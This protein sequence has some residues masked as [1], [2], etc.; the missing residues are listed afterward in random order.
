[1]KGERTL[2]YSAGELIYYNLSSGRIS[3]DGMKIIENGAILVEGEKILDMGEADEFLNKL[4]LLK[5]RGVDLGERVIT[6]GLI[7]A[8]THPVFNDTRE[9]EFELCNSGMSYA[10]I[11]AAG[12]GIQSSVR[13]FRSATR[14]RLLD[15]L[16]SRLDTFLSF[17][18][19]TIEAK[20][21]YGLSLEDEIKSLELLKTAGKLHPVDIVPTFLGAHHIPEEYSRD[22]EV[23]IS[24]II[25]RMLPEIAERKLARFCDVFCEEGVFTVEESRRILQAAKKLGFGL[26]IHA[27]EFSPSGGSELAAQLEAVSADH[28]I[29][30][31]DEGID[32][33]SRKGVI[34][35]LLP[36]TSFFLG[37]DSYA[38]G[39]RFLEKNVIFAIATDFN[40][41]TCM[42][43]SMPLVMTIACIK[44]GLTALQAIQA[45]TINAASATGMERSRGNIWP[46]Y[47]ADFVVWNVENHKQIP[48]HFGVNHV[49]AVIKGGKLVWGEL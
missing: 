26:K 37:L 42:T 22:R 1:M 32:E 48:Y 18:T 4:N 47:T 44:F 23:Y 11:A 5:A 2:Y 19:T 45:S 38:P 33:I 30:I 35:V 40:P 9:E 27:D 17:G 49:K 46:G 31:S 24:L 6:A 21:G 13:S 15:L 39:A 25:D 7:D 34:P 3:W 43:E 41:G 14:E 28:L 20:S 8:H 29:E 10:E 36:G 12:G 16:L